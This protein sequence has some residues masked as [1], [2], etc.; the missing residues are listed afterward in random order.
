MAEEARV[1]ISAILETGE[2]TK[3]EEP[4]N[5][6]KLKIFEEIVKDEPIMR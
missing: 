6:D 4:E 2:V 1:A 5:V 3:F